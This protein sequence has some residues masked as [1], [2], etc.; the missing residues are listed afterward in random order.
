MT[1]IF[2]DVFTEL[3]VLL[4]MVAVI[5]ARLVSLR[6]YRDM[7]SLLTSMIPLASHD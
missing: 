5:G 2:G 4:L 1:P 7:L 6:D 3:A